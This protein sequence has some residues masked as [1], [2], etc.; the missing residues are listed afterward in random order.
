M[1]EYP[2]YFLNK[3]L[4]YFCKID[5]SWWLDGKK[6]LLMNFNLENMDWTWHNKNSDT[7]QSLDPNLF[8][9]SK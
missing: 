8:G 2:N 9:S 7:Q 1:P 6:H 3:H 4:G 5:D